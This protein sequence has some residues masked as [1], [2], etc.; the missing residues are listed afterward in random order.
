MFSAAGRSYRPPCSAARYLGTLCAPAVHN[1]RDP[2]PRVMRELLLLV[3]GR[4][5]LLR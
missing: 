4:V 3:I 5:A 2:H 1:R